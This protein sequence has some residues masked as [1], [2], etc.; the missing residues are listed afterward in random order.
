MVRR[1]KHKEINMKTI[2]TAII[3]FSGL[4]GGIYSLYWQ[5]KS[6]QKQTKEY[7]ANNALNIDYIKQKGFNMICGNRFN[8]RI[9]INSDVLTQDL[10]E[11][12]D[13]YADVDKYGYYVRLES[14]IN[15]VS[16]NLFSGFIRTTNDFDTVLSKLMIH[17]TV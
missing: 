7:F 4:F 11:I 13:L 5:A 1:T 15:N 8:L 2:I 3:I 6:I 12:I 10:F 14:K 17:E 16:I 9:K